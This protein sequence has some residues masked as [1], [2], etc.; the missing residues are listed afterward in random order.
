MKPITLIA[1]LVSLL[2][3]AHASAL[4]SPAPHGSPAAVAAAPH[5]VKLSAP[6][7]GTNP[8]NL[9]Y[10]VTNVTTVN[11]L[12]PSGNPVT[13]FN[14]T[15]RQSQA[16]Q[17]SAYSGVTPQGGLQFVIAV[18]SDFSTTFTVGQFY[19]LDLTSAR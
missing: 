1:A 15:L 4:P 8:H 3:C 13:T 2:A 9:L 7:T 18:P 12:D 17:D 14:V 10:E 16:A 11:S 19:F 5:R 6:N